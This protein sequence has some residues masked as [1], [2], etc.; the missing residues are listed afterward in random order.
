MGQEMHDDLRSVQEL[1]GHQSPRPDVVDVLHRGLRM[2]RRQLEKTK[3]AATTRPRRSRSRSTQDGRYIPADVRRAVRRRDGDQCTFVSEAGRRCSAKAP[4]EFDHIVEVARGGKPTVGNLRLLCR[5][6]NQ[7]EAERTFGAEFIRR[8]K[9]T[10]RAEK[11]ALSHVEEVIPLLRSL[12]FR[13]D[14][15]NQAAALCENVPDAHSRSECA[16]P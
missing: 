12:R 10:R 11:K 9:E 5:A 8:K 15:A 13:A 2:L 14:E 3:Y 1:L 16:S 6:H 7:Y 4:L